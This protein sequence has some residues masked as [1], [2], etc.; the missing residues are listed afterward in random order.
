[1]R[2]R[3]ADIAALIGR[4]RRSAAIVAA[5]VGGTAA[6]GLATVGGA[7]SSAPGATQ[8]QPD[9][10]FPVTSMDGSS[11][12]QGME[13]DMAGETVMVKSAP[14]AVLAKADR[15]PLPMK[16]ALAG[17]ATSATELSKPLDMMAPRPIAYSVVVQP[18]FENESYVMPGAAYASL[19]LHDGV[20]RFDRPRSSEPMGAIPIHP[21]ETPEIAE[22]ED[23]AQPTVLSVPLPQ[24]K[25]LLD[26]NLPLP[27]MRP[28]IPAM[29]AIPNPGRITPNKPGGQQQQDIADAGTA[30]GA[31]PVMRQPQ[32]PS[33]ILAFL[34]PQGDAPQP[35][36]TPPITQP[37]NTIVTP[38]PFGIPYV[39]QTQTVDTA[40][41]KPE[42]LEILRTIENHYGRKVVI[43]SGYR[44]RGREG[45]LHRTCRAA[46][47]IVP[48]ISSQALAT[49]ARTSP[50]VGGVGTY[51]HESMIHVDI[52]TPRDWKYGC[53]SYF[54]MRDGSAHWGKVPTSIED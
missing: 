17:S 45:S 44:S 4:H 20:L 29:V 51:C 47:I 34:T 6:L 35:G 38:T 18:G 8:F 13:S 15:M 40:C 37:P 11:A 21:A 22:E 10:Q 46:D 43:T 39:L 26:P 7:L 5:L 9:P 19:E 36:I 41:L 27:K 48:G 30:P 3:R 25:P 31:I 50:S 33:N 32:K 53:G 49:Y 24:A 14:H 16:L 1:V 12:P 2:R 23:D 28:E 42:L 52:G 54:A